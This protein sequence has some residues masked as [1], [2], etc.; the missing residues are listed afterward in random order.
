[1]PAYLV[2]SGLLDVCGLFSGNCNPSTR[3]LVNLR[4]C[5]GGVW[6]ASDPKL[7]DWIWYQTIPKAS[8]SEEA[9]GIFSRV[10]FCW[11]SPVLKEGYKTTLSLRGLPEIHSKLSSGTLRTKALESWDS[12]SEPVTKWTLPSTLVRCLKDASLSP[13][14]P[15]LFVILFRYVQ[16][17]FMGAAIRFVKGTPS[18]VTGDSGSRLILYAVVIYVGMAVRYDSFIYQHQINRLRIM[19]R[20]ALIG[21]IHNQSLNIPSTGSDSE[22]VTLMSSDVDSVEST[23]EIFHETWAQLLEVLVGTVLLAA[24]IQWFAL[25]PLV[26][27]FGCSRMSAYVAKHLEGRQKAWNV[28]TQARIATITAA[29]GGIKSLKM[30][31]MEDAI[32]SRISD[33]RDNELRMSERLRWILVA[34]NASAN[35][36]GIF[37]PVLTLIAYAMSSE[38]GGLRANEVFTSI[39]LLAMVTHPANMVMTLIPRAVAV[40]ANF[41]RIQAYLSK[42][43]IQDVREYADPSSR[44]SASMDNV[45]IKPPSVPRPILEDV[46]LNLKKGE[47]VVC[48]GAVG[49]GKTTLAM[50]LLGEAHLISG[51]IRLA[52]KKIAYCAQA[53]WLPSVTIRDA[54]SGGF[55]VDHR[56]YNT[57]LDACSLVPDLEA[58]SAGDRTMIENNGINL[59]GGQRQRIALARAVYSRYDMLVLD[60]PFSA[61]DGAVTD[62]IVGNLFGPES[63]FRKTG[64]TV[65]LISNS[66][67]LFPLADRLLVLRDSK[68]HLQDPTSF[69][70]KEDWAG[71][72]V[73]TDSQ[74]TDTQRTKNP[75]QKHRMN[76]AADDVSRR[77]GDMA[78][79]GYYL[80]AVG[81]S[82]V[83]VMTG[84]AATYSFGLTFS[85]YVLKWATES[86]SDELRGYL[87]LY[88]VISFIAWAA[89]S[90]TMWS[91]QMKIAIRSGMVLHAQLLARVLSAPLAYFTETDIGATLNR[92]AQD[93]TLIDKQLP[94]ALANLN[95]QIF[96]LLMQV[97]LILCVQP[98][99]I[100]TVPICSLCVYILQRIYLRTSR[101]LRFLDIESR[102]QLYTNFL[103]TANGVTT[104]RAFG[105]QD[106]FTAENIQALDLS[107]KPFYLLLCLQCWL[108]VILDCLVAIVAVI[109]M[110]LTVMYKNTT[111][112]ADIGL[113]LNLIIVANTTLLRLVQNWTSLETSLG[114][115]ARLKSVQECAPSEDRG[116]GAL[117]PE[118]RWPVGEVRIDD[119]SVAYS[120]ASELAL[121]NVSLHIKLGQKLIVMGRTGSGKSTLMLSLLQLLDTE[122]GSIQIDDVDISR[123]SLR[124]L[125]QRGFIA[126]P[127][128]GFNIPTASLRFNLDPHHTSTDEAIATAL[129]RTHLWDKIS[130]S[131]SSAPPDQKIK[132]IDLIELLSRPMSTFLPL[133]AGQL[134]LF[135][136]CRTLLRVQANKSTKPI[137][138]LDEASSS[139]D[140]ETESILAG[141]LRGDFRDHAVVMIAHRVE[142]IM[143]A[144]RPGVDAVATM[145]GGRVQKVCLIGLG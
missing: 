95:T 28:A 36:L 23:G 19:V 130:S 78:V 47:I 64:T 18:E 33:L 60:D 143:H 121:R 127:Q 80:N 90:G 13:I 70:H 142:G 87:A 55:D 54:I 120:Q 38:S 99:M 27:I 17:I 9:A 73:S 43:S 62:R 48:A 75:D 139:L 30:M 133:S 12:R 10:F 32:E 26:I 20:G 69:Q 83:L 51:S 74:P 97:I 94:P 58:L 141:I 104:I 1:M 93:I 108:K 14:I 128:D 66:T 103:D 132:T 16:L 24:R 65:F 125:R 88:A 53:A 117:E 96:K 122:E 138:I 134:Q 52:S 11:I 76:D 34:Y 145:Q 21:L 114:A 82:N 109:L 106:K 56:W 102:S 129:K 137:I 105:W 22:G 72:S 6:L 44:Q 29:L 35:A 91:T 42:P 50:N 119:V 118:P 140:P 3:Q 8:T 84:C 46:C 100:M 124:T 92:F 61:L 31:G 135:A 107:Q 15:R 101:Q 45:S 81:L 25:L 110:G 67:R 37:A 57:V 115:I 39:A 136:L 2:L 59:S 144:M 85:Q 86:S 5:L 98:V 68:A 113:A 7:R 41:A 79:Y 131:C 63:L 40:M 112:G 77:T 89:T 126:V 71:A 111:T 49:S 116:L 4:V 123:V